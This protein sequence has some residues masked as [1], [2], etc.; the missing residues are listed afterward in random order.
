MKRTFIFSLLILI[1]ICLVTYY[2]SLSLELC[3]SQD[4]NTMLL[5]YILP[6]PDYA[7]E[8]SSNTLVYYRI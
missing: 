3:S 1:I 4:I 5:K 7:S 6:I 8:E 2:H